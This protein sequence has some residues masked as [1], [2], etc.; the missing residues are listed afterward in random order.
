[1]TCPH[2]KPRPVGRCE[3][4]SGEL[5]APLA[6]RVQ[7]F[8]GANGFE[9]CERFR[10]AQEPRTPRSAQADTTAGRGGDS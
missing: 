7:R 1:M 9:C 10:Q 8:C 4:S 3:A 6:E 2:F 5:F